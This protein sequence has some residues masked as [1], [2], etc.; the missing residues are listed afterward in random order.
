[1]LDSKFASYILCEIGGLDSF[2][3]TIFNNQDRQ[4]TQ[5]KNETRL[6]NF[7]CIYTAM[8]STAI[9]PAR[10]PK[11][12]R[13]EYVALPAKEDEGPVN[14][15]KTTTPMNRGTARNRMEISFRQQRGCILRY[16]SFIVVALLMV[17]LVVTL[18]QH[19][20]H[21][22]WSCVG[23]GACEGN[24]GTIG[25]GSCN[26]NGACR[27]NTGNV[28]WGS[29]NGN[30]VC[31]YNTGYVQHMSCNGDLSCY[32]NQGPIRFGSCN[33]EG[34]CHNSTG[35]VDKGACNGKDACHG[36]SQSVSPGTCNGEH[37]CPGNS[38]TI[39]SMNQ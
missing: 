19:V 32:R 10:D 2:A 27:H 13:G 37:T 5:Q 21:R 1:V 36:N 3:P 4:R 9:Y 26:G 34:A 24:L 17:A 25:I 20:A 8:A 12:A 15:G 30:G 39:A 18:A 22:R 14:P 16:T 7:P 35:P 31:K 28:T 38:T 23:D 6:K 29:C 11:S 33:G